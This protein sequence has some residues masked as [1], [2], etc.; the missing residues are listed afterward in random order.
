MANGKPYISLDEDLD[1]GSEPMAGG[2]GESQD[3]FMGKTTTNEYMPNG[4]EV[5]E[6]ITM[7]ATKPVGDGNYQGEIDSM[8]AEMKSGSGE[9]VEEV[10]QEVVA[11]GNL[12][13]LE[14]EMLE[15]AIKNYNSQRDKAHQEIDQVYDRMIQVTEGKIRGLTKDV[16]AEV[17]M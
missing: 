11:G 4:G 7:Q 5:T 16:A 6:T 1:I 10:K 17:G 8:M 12:S 9:A 3:V 2:A 14:Q 13:S 15:V